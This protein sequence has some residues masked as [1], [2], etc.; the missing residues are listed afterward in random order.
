[1][2]L[3]VDRAIQAHG[4]GGV[5]GDFSWPTLGRTLRQPMDPMSAPGSYRPAGTEGLHEHH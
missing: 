3:S 4:G 1:M 2:A 5:S